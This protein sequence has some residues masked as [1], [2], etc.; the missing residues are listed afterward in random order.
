[1]NN[2]PPFMRGKY[3][4][5]YEAYVK[6]AIT[7]ERETSISE[8]ERLLLLANETLKGLCEDYQAQIK[9][10]SKAREYVPMNNVDMQKI[11]ADSDGSIHDGLIALE[12]AIIQRAN[13][14]VK[15][16]TNG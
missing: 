11:W 2:I 15:E 4:K 7:K 16:N 1:M 6:E 10:L 5:Q 12:Q 13:L 14:I 3:R 8:I 9:E